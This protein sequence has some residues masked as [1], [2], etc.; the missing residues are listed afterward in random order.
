[1]TYKMFG[2]TL[3]LT[4]S[5]NHLNVWLL[6]L[7][8]E[9][10]VFISVQVSVTSA[11]LRVI[12]HFCYVIFATRSYSNCMYYTDV[13]LTVPVA[14]VIFNILA[15]CLINSSGLLANP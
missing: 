7:T 2:G 12:L 9:R 8:A 10:D 1:M 11:E 4:Q 5:F 15:N 3:S 6:L 14:V 13:E